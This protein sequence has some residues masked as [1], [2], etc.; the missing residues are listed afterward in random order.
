[1]KVLRH[2]VL[3]N[4]GG[5][6]ERDQIVKQVETAI[7]KMVW[8]LGSQ[9][10]SINPTQKGNGVKPIKTACMNHLKNNGWE[11]EKRLQISSDIRPGP[12]DAVK[13]VGGN[14]IFALEW[15]TGNISSSH[16]AVNKMVLGMLERV[17]V[18]GILILPSRAMYKY[19]TDR[20]GNF[21]ELSPYFITFRNLN[22]RDGYLAVIEIEHDEVDTQALL[23]PKGTDGMALF[24]K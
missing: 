5:L 9:K 16:R 8:P 4:R 13:P 7:S 24:Q 14:R 15:E 22:L 21:Q 18:G 12:L 19:L 3:V 10:F 6:P 11:L 17:L 2:E 23:I 1:M 20:V